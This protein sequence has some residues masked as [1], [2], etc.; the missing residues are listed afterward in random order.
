[1]GYIA[2]IVNFTAQNYHERVIIPDHDPVSIEKPYPV[3]LEKI[4]ASNTH[5]NMFTGQ[6]FNE[7]KDHF[8]GQPKHVI[9]Q[10]TNK[11]YAEMTGIGGQV[12]EYV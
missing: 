10:E 6:D 4:S 7:P 5:S 8:N 3:Q 1:M 12:N 9:S 11:L 2:P